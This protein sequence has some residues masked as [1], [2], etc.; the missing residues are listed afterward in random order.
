MISR[1]RFDAFPLGPLARGGDRVGVDPVAEHVQIVRV[2]VDAG[3]LDRRHALDARLGSGRDRVG[4]PGHGVV[5]GQ[6][7]HLH[8]SL[9]CGLGDRRRRE[10]SIRYGRMSLQIDHRAGH[11]AETGAQTELR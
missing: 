11:C 1:A 4:D 8:T 2:P 3:E 7:H 9:G 5:V 6:R 10:L